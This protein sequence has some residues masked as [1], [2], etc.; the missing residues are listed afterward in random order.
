MMVTNYI[1]LAYSIKIDNSDLIIINSL[2]TVIAS[3]FVT[4]YLYVKFKVG[5]ITIHLVR[6]VVGLIF[7]FCACSSLTDPWLNGLLATSMSMCQYIF[8]LEG[9]KGVL[10]TKDPAKVDLIIAVACI[11]NSIAWG[12]YAQL[13][14]DIFVF[15]PNVAA[16]TAGCINICLYMWTTDRLKDS[17]MPIKVLHKCC[18]K[19]ARFLPN[20]VKDD[21]EIESEGL[22]YV[23]EPE[24]SNSHGVVQRESTADHHHITSTKNGSGGSSTTHV[25]GGSEKKEELDSSESDED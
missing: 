1:W 21:K 9:V 16:F 7:A 4:L 19:Q 22:F 8:I 15:I 10:Q 12:V 18:N 11:F 3:S 2:G 23:K 14:G 5:R 25:N 20:K 17:S 6:L 13:V 24:D